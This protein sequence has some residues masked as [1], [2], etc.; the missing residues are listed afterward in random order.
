M[1]R[2]HKFLPHQ[3]ESLQSALKESQD[4]ADRVE[5]SLTDRLRQSNTSLA[6]AQVE[7]KWSNILF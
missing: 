5:Q 6:A 7:K 1:T 3:V 2:T 4:N